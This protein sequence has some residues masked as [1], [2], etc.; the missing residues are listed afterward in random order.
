MA[1]PWEKYG[2]P[3]EEE[4]GPWSKYSAPDEEQSRMSRAADDALA[5][6]RTGINAITGMAGTALGGLGSLMAGGNLDQASAAGAHISS[7][8]NIPPLGPKGR[9]N[10]EMIGKAYD[11]V[12]SGVGDIGAADLQGLDSGKSEAKA[13][14][15]YEG[16]FDFAAMA[17]MLKAGE[18]KGP[19]LPEG[20]TAAYEAVRKSNPEL[21]GKTDAAIKQHYV[22]IDAK[23]D[24]RLQSPEVAQILQR[25]QERAIEEGKMTQNAA[26]RDAQMQQLESQMKAEQGEPAHGTVTP[27]DL[28]KQQEPLKLSDP[29]SMNGGNPVPEELKGGPSENPVP[30]EANAVE[31]PPLSLVDTENKPASIDYSNPLTEHVNERLASVPEGIKGD[32]VVQRLMTQIESLK[33]SMQ[34]TV[35]KAGTALKDTVVPTGK[36]M[37]VNP[38][39]RAEIKRVQT[40]HSY[41]AQKLDNALKQ[42]DNRVDSLKGESVTPVVKKPLGGTGSKGFG[43]GGAVQL[44]HTENLDRR[45]VKVHTDPSREDAATLAYRSSYGELRGLH[46]PD[47]GKTHWW[48]A[49]L[50]T[51]QEMYGPLGVKQRIPYADSSPQHLF[52]KKQEVSDTGYRFAGE[53]PNPTTP[54]TT[55]DQPLGQSKIGGSQRGSIG[56]KP[57][58]PFTKFKN[59]LPEPLKVHADTI[60]KEQ[61]KPG[62]NTNLTNAAEVAKGEAIDSIV[63]KGLAK[64][65]PLTKDYSEVRDSIV[66]QADYKGGTGRIG[67]SLV[68]GAKLFAQQTG[69]TAIRWVG[70][71][72]NASKRAQEIQVYNRLFKEGGVIHS[73]EKLSEKEQGSLWKVMKEN[74][75]QKWLSEDE[76]KGHGF[77]DKQIT[78]YNAAKTQLAIILE[79]INEV[80]VA[81][82]MEPI[83]P[84][85]GY[86]PSRWKGSHYFEV[87]KRHSDGNLQIVRI[88]TGN[89]TGLAAKVFGGLDQTREKFMQ[90]HGHEFEVGPIEERPAHGQNKD[91]YGLFNH[92]LDTVGRD[93]PDRAVLDKVFDQ[94][95][96]ELAD[97]T[98]RFRKHFDV[99]RGVEGFKG[100][101]F[102][103]TDIQNAKDAMF[104]LEGYTKDAYDYIETTKTSKQINK[105]LFDPDF[106]QPNAEAYIRRYWDKSRGV[107][108][109]L[110]SVVN[111]VVGIPAQALGFSSYAPQ[112]AMSAMKKGLSIFFLGLNRPVFL[113]SQ[114]VQPIQFMTPYLMRMKAD[115]GDSVFHGHILTSQAKGYFDTLG[116]LTG[117]KYMSAFG[118]EAMKSALDNRY[119]EA[120]FLEDIK[121]SGNQTAN[122]LTR[123][124][125]G[126]T[127]LVASEKYSRSVAFYTFAHFL[128]ETNLKGADLFKAAADATDISMTNYKTH[129]RSMIYSDMGV[130]GDLVSP[131][132]TF[133]NNYF[134]QLYLYSKEAMT[135]HN[136]A[137]TKPLF[138]FLATQFAVGGYM[139]IPGRQGADSIIDFARENNWLSPETKNVTQL[140]AKYSDK[141]GGGKNYVRYGAFSGMTGKD[142]SPTFSAANLIPENGLKGLMPY[143]AKVWD[144][145]SHGYEAAKSG[146]QSKVDNEA[147]LKSATPPA[148]QFG[149]EMHQQQPDGMIPNP[150]KNMAGTVKRG[151][152]SMS[153]PAWQARILGTRTIKESEQNTASFQSKLQEKAITSTKQNLLDQIVKNHISGQPINKQIQQYMSYGGTSQAAMNDLVKNAIAQHQTNLEQAKGIPNNLGSAMKYRRAGEY[154]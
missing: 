140:L 65:I 22:D 62:L 78:A 57:E 39:V 85:P 130:L 21:K 115:M 43:Q 11:W 50:A 81:Q 141:L 122:Q 138:A 124:V 80:R 16:G 25:N 125:T 61:N 137:Y 3:P 116:M 121:N 95:N 90:E 123:L 13:R 56:F 144:I 135:N 108:S 129:E 2:G 45:P 1:G 152:P 149:T 12:K 132:T 119:V 71:V 126:E 72:V 30:Y 133:R 153:D 154:K 96:S 131:L 44:V 66:G 26:A 146:F 53:T 42:L 40:D 106:K 98:R 145:A 104:S 47:T 74:K 143:L 101:S 82:K 142:V 147:L 5:L 7:A 112:V 48:D 68:P 59:A 110:A 51:H 73:F 118:K 83:E 14:S 33:Q 87:Y 9:A 36:D 4:S 64:Y 19:K 52:L 75:M 134:A 37:R 88:E 41:M 63:G 86:F 139:G 127:A 99:N 70:D 97:R 8:L 54:W 38:M 120:H 117:G 102:D 84:I 93:T 148:F 77:G 18:G 89:R 111:N 109:Q 113:L 128:S 69:N 107:E 10:D 91:T 55:M 27:A 92:L 114:N 79:H 23:A 15:L 32:T 6:P 49:G 60:W 136:L 35:D 67:R 76:L 105:L 20:H 24:Q 103:K 28:Q 100:D 31:K 58:D 150:D 29:N 46:D 34:D 94:Y 17:G 151:P